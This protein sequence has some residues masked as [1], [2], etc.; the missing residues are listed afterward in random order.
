L[1]GY[2]FNFCTAWLY[3][4]VLSNKSSNQNFNCDPR[5]SFYSVGFNSTCWMISITLRLN[6]PCETFSCYLCRLDQ[7][8]QAHPLCCV[9]GHFTR[10]RNVE[11]QR[12]IQT[13]L[14]LLTEIDLHIAP[15]T[16]KTIILTTLSSNQPATNTLSAV[17][18]AP[19]G[20]NFDLSQ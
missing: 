15:V 6:F 14:I 1:P 5:C 12:F 20:I 4:I 8:W 2:G 3:N 16:S 18:R 9:T 11:G 10:E 17:R 19:M 7:C 13:N